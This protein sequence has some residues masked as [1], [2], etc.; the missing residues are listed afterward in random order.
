MVFWAALY[1]RETQSAI[2]GFDL[3]KFRGR[4]AANLPTLLKC[5]NFYGGRRY[6][7]YVYF[8]T[9]TEKKCCSFNILKNVVVST[10]LPLYI[11]LTK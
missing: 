11:Y 3:S 4:Q 7:A 9:F 2:A 10:F 8:S 6:A 1:T 5:S